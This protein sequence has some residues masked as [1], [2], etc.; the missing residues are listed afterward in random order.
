MF[1]FFFFFF[2]CDWVYSDKTGENFS[3]LFCFIS[4]FFLGVT[5]SVRIRRLNISRHYYV[6]S[7]SFSLYLL[8][9]ARDSCKKWQEKKD[10]LSLISGMESQKF[11]FTI[12][13]LFFFGVTG[14]VRIK[15]LNISRHFTFLFIYYTTRRI[16]VE[17]WQKK[18]DRLG[19]ISSLVVRI[20]LFFSFLFPSYD[21]RFYQEYLAEWTW[22]KEEGNNVQLSDE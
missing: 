1:F 17:K 20:F 5:G 22:K 18:N 19:P 6:L 9:Y 12:L 8:Y 13:F 16:A 14:S 4:F 21:Q 3:S 2:W 11:L 15:Q 10:R 7:S